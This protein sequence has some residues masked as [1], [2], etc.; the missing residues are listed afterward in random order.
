MW[1][2]AMVATRAK[3][4]PRHADEVVG[5]DEA[6]GAAPIACLHKLWLESRPEVGER[7]GG[8]ERDFAS[9]R[10]FSLPFAPAPFKILF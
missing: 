8:K 9:N 5:A 4:R 3:Q 10:L 6:V 1:P 2:Q 7:T